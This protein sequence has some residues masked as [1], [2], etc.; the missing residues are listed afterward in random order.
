MT[1]KAIIAF[2]ASFLLDLYRYSDVTAKK[3]FS[4]LDGLRDQIWLPHQA[5]YEFHK[6]RIKVISQL[7]TKHSQVLNYLKEDGA[8]LLADIK[9]ECAK[10]PLLD[11]DRITKP[12][13]IAI[14]KA[15]NR[16][17]ELGVKHPQM[18]LD[19]SDD[20]IWSRVD[21]LFQ[22]KIGDEYTDEQL[23]T[24]EQ[25]AQK[26]LAKQIPP[27]FRDQKKDYPHGDYLVWR[28]LLDHC[29]NL[30]SPAFFVTSDVK[31][32]WWLEERGQKLGALPALRKE[33]R[34]ECGQDFHIYETTNFVETFAPRFQV[35]PAGAVEEIQRI[36]AE[37]DQSPSS[38]HDNNLLLIEQQ[39]KLKDFLG[40][41]KTVFEQ[42]ADTPAGYLEFMRQ[43]KT[44][45]DFLAPQKAVLEQL[46]GVQSASGNLTDFL[47]QQ[48]TL[49]SLQYLNLKDYLGIT[50]TVQEAAREF[51]QLEK[52]SRESQDKF[53]E[54]AEKKKTKE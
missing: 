53:F 41:Q 24:V 20:R 37:K 52:S 44:L 33:F 22:G 12:L 2:D 19:P 21:A 25:T 45:K 1:P 8:K 6:N 26:R 35:A 10:H 51:A 27:G 42:F 49:Q 7:R 28:Q 5:A 23:A 39:Q 30:Q 15:Q 40:P 16:I 31:E 4:V 9:K 48:K 34:Q 50:S 46:G 18:T 47:K 13:R 29:K 43:E 54:A 36:K 14:E 11:G 17:S 38:A 32:D 3:M